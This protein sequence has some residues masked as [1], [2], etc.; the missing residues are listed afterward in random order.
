MTTSRSTAPS[1]GVIPAIRRA[2]A[3]GLATTLTGT[4]SAHE[5]WFIDDERFSTDLASAFTPEAVW[6]VAAA[7][8]FFLAAWGLWRL[9]D[10]RNLLPGPELFRAS[11]QGLSAL[12][13]LVPLILGVHLAVPLLIAGVSGNLLSPDVVLGGGWRYVLGL[14]Q[15]GAALSL[16]YGGFTRAAA[17]VL[18]GLWLLGLWVASPVAMLENAHILGFA[19]FFFLAGRGPLSIDRLIFPRLEPPAR[20]VRRAVPALR[21][22]AGVSFI[23]VAFTE[24]LANL[25][26]ALAF[27]E[28]YPLNFTGEMGLPIPDSPFILGAGAVELAIGLLLLFNVFVRETIVVAWLPFNLTLTVFNWVELV[29]HLPFYG[30]MA[31]LLVWGGSS[32]DRDLWVAGVC[33]EPPDQA[34]KYSGVAATTE[35][36]RD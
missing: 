13:G 31:I 12:Y 19:A 22:F 33:R 36:N 32:L 2:A 7:L 30:I 24:K 5:K 6:F 21:V 4:G 16:F 1:P 25:P 3:A 35:T 15:T 17:L 18:A 14:V 29:G 20:L 23:V 10:R 9:R 11:S 26:L 28:R 27:L 34:R 8:V